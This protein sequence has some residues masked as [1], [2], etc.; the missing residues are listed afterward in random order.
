MPGGRIRTYVSTAERIAER[1]PNRYSAS[2][3]INH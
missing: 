1:I 2:V 3:V